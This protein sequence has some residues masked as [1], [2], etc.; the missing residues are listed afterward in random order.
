MN[1]SLNTTLN[2]TGEMGADRG[3]DHSTDR[4]TDRKTDHSMNRKYEALKEILRQ[5]DRVLLAFSGGVDSAFLLRVASEELNG[6]LLA[7]TAISETTPAHEQEEAVR[8]AALCNAQHLTVETHELNDPEFTSN[9]EE[10]CYICKKYR[11]GLLADLAVEKG[12]PVVIDGTNADDSKDFR[13]GMRALRELSVRSPLAE[14]GLTKSEIRALSKQLDLPTWDKP[15]YA[16]LAT[17]I[18]CGSSITG[19]RLSR[20]DRA[21]DFLRGLGVKGQVR[22]RDYGEMCRI[23]SASDMIQT[24]AAPEIREQIVN[25]FSKIGYKFVTIDLAGYRMGSVVRQS[26]PEQNGS[27][28][29]R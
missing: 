27:K 8:I 7:V 1:G 11:F 18:P 12:Y 25:H 20:I 6:N 16:C 5:M 15:A 17:R 28:Q 14:A 21:E 13:P 9:P 23:E 4:K 26:A 3:M 29:G 2:T 10:K 22:V 24:I 19:E